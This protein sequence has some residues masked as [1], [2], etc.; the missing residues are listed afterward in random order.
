[1]NPAEV[2]YVFHTRGTLLCPL[3]AS[4]SQSPL[5]RSQSCF[6]V[7][8]PTPP[9]PVA[10]RALGDWGVE[11]FNEHFLALGMVL[12]VGGTAANIPFPQSKIVLG[13]PPEGRGG[14]NSVAGEGQPSKV[15]RKS[16]EGLPAALRDQLCPRQ[17]EAGESRG[18]TSRCSS[19]WGTGGL[20]E[21]PKANKH[22]F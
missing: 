8:P 14:T 5:A 11:L 22:P 7:R 6:I 21:H 9:L 1:M 19:P 12:G 16:R 13:G 20:S 2:A 15:E 10:P 18:R 17:A 3:T 4:E